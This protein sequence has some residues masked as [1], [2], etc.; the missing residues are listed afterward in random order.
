MACTQTVNALTNANL[1]GTGVP[2]YYVLGNKVA[3][4]Y[5]D[6]LDGSWDAVSVG[7]GRDESGSSIGTALTQVWSGCNDAETSHSTSFLG[8]TANIQVTLPFFT[9]HGLNA[10]QT[11]APNVAHSTFAM[12]PIFQ[13]PTEVSVAA[14]SAVV[15][16]GQPAVLNAT[17]S[18]SA[19]APTGGYTIPVTINAAPAQ[20]NDAVSPGDFTPPS[21]L[22]IVI[23]A[24]ASSGSL[25]VPTIDNV[26]DRARKHIRLSGL[27]A[28]QAA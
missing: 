9:N 24:G 25:S 10:V 16:E 17:L 28:F 6:F 7:S 15:T 13:I 14:D 22:Q 8:A 12:S 1:G 27:S 2:I 20:A 5:G 26:G 11:R 3:D 23:A 21:P 19:V 4:D 18:G